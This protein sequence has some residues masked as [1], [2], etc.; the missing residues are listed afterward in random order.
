MQC[1]LYWKNVKKSFCSSLPPS[2]RCSWDCLSWSDMDRQRPPPHSERVRERERE[3]ERFINGAKEGRM[4]S[5]AGEKVR[6]WCN[7]L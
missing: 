4:Q 3:R 2:L 7:D 5:D 1:V 6:I